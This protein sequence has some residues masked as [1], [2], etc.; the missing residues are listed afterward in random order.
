MSRSGKVD[1]IPFGRIGVGVGSVYEWEENYEFEEAWL[2]K[3][4]D[5]SRMVSMIWSLGAQG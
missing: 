5:A 4:L 3:E 2:W 1:P